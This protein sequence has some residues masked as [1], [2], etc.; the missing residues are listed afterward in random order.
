MCANFPLAALRTIEPMA[1]A[2][3]QPTPRPEVAEGMA[4][5]RAR[6]VRIGRPPGPLPGAASRAAELRDQGL[7]LAQIAAAL[8]EE[9]VPTPSGRERWHKSSVQ[10]V[11]ARWDQAHPEIT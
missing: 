4:A 10:H 1:E 11:L 8:T 2:D 5:A 3:P 7:S 6:G 9:A